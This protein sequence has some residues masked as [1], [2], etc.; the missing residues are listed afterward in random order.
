MPGNR[1]DASVSRVLR[2]FD[3][4]LDFRRIRFCEITLGLVEDVLAQGTGR[5]CVMGVGLDFAPLVRQAGLLRH[6]CRLH[7]TGVPEEVLLLD[8]CAG[9]PPWSRTVRWG[10]LLP[11]VYAVDDGFWC[12]GP[13]RILQFAY[14]PPWDV[15]R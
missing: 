15:P 4:D 8:D 1:V 6:V 12:I 7:P 14:A 5:G 9:D 11:R 13:R 10:A 3:A 2:E